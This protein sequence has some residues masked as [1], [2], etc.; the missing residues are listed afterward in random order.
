MTEWQVREL[1]GRAI[2]G[3][4]GDD[5]EESTGFDSMDVMTLSTHIV[6]V[7]KKFTDLDI[8]QELGEHSGKM[9]EFG[10]PPIEP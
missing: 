3:W 7:L 6:D 1:V 5:H 9:S 4:I 2:R 8:N 10:Q